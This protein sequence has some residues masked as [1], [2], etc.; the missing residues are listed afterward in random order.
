MKCLGERNP[1]KVGLHLASGVSW[2]DLLHAL[3]GGV[4]S[5]LESSNDRGIIGLGYLDCIP[6]VI[7]MTVRQNNC[8][9]LN[10]TR[11]MYGNRIAGQK[12]INYNGI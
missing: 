1:A 7:R 4:L 9:A 10:L 5:D 11:R 12:W 3:T 6:K 8:L 2:L